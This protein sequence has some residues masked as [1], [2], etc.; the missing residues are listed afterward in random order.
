MSQQ[1]PYNPVKY[2]VVNYYVHNWHRGV[3]GSTI[4]YVLI[5]GSLHYLK[6]RDK[7]WKN[8]IALALLLSIDFKPVQHLWLIRC[9]PLRPLR[10]LLPS[11]IVSVA[12]FSTIYIE[13][14]TLTNHAHPCAIFTILYQVYG[15]MSHVTLDPRLPLFSRMRWKDQG[16]W[17]RSYI[18]QHE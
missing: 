6:S 5:C 11:L 18:H 3:G 16:A 12:F 7:C 14:R 4:T 15:H 8:H 17:G 13:P 1:Y 9:S 10:I 2:V